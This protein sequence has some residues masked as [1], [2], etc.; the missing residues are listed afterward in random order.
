VFNRKYKVQSGWMFLKG[1]K[2]VSAG[3]IEPSTR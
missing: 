2:L 1:E 3:G